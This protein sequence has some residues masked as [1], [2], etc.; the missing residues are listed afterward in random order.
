ML[1]SNYCRVATLLKSVFDRDLQANRGPTSE[2]AFSYV[3]GR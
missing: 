3:V 2:F 1:G